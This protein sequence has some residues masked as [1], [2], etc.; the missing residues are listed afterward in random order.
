MII[1]SKWF[2]LTSVK[3]VASS[4]VTANVPTLSS[5]R[6]TAIYNLPLKE[7]FNHSILT[8]ASVL[9]LSQN[10]RPYYIICD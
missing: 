4:L 1:V 8:Y 5:T 2:V 9:Q 6:V 7:D 10:I 3:L